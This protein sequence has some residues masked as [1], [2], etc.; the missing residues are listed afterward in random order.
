MNA[1]YAPVHSHINE[2]P[3]VNKGGQHTICLTT[4]RRLVVAW[5]PH[6]KF[7]SHPPGFAA[8]GPAEVHCLVELIKQLFQGN[9]K[10]VNNERRQ[11][12]EMGCI[13]FAM[14]NH[15][16]GTMV[17]AFLGSEG[18][19]GVFTCWH[20]CLPREC[21]KNSFHYPKQVETNQHSKVARFA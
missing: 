18:M 11:I 3:R 14:D 6:H 21:N 17:Q 13:C 2:K 12:F 8:E 20:D 4:D 15:F 19:S 10:D 9:A 7:Y 1:S 5:T 16:S